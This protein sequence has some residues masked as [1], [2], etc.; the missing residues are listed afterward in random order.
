[1]SKY[2]LLSITTIALLLLS[3]VSFS[4]SAPTGTANLGILTSF[5][6]YTGA[7]GVGNSG[8]TI[9]GDAGTNF[10]SVTGDPAT[11]DTYEEDAI[12]AQAKFDLLRLYIHLN[13]LFVDFPGTH[14]ATFANETLPPGV[15]YT[16][17]AGSFGGNVILDG[18]GDPDAFF[19]FKFL[20]A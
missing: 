6:T 8:G 16:S 11:G 7:G 17:S 2:I 19:I 15:Y 1:M 4:Q 20:G 14:A 3:K 12:T 10:G 5:A 13:D 18:G 9:D